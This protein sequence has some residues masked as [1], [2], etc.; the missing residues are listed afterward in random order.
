M[1]EEMKEAARQAEAMRAQLSLRD[2][3]TSVKNNEKHALTAENPVTG[4]KRR[5]LLA[6]I[7]GFSGAGKGTLIK[8]LMKEYDNYSLS[9]SATTRAPRPGEQD[10]KDYFFV[11]RERFLDMIKNDE[12]LE[13]ANYVDHYYGTP[14][15]YVEEQ[16]EAGRDVILEIEIQGALKI[17]AKFP[18]SV[19]IFIT[20]PSAEELKARLINRGTETE[21]VIQK[22]LERAALEAVGVETYDYI[23]IN[24][25]LDKT[26]KHLNY[27]IQDQ[28]M[29][30]NQ[31]L[32]FLEDMQKQL[33]TV[34]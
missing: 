15:A 12:L 22:R 1:S 20:P 24:D 6:V 30:A 27:L 23:L 14:K 19:L 31:Q 21:E 26:T 33:R 16:I 18:E 29:R 4:Q 32:T 11:S 8:R 5:G 25:N 3:K 17:R 34:L 9:I 13:Y 28:H 7:S 10:G 2:E